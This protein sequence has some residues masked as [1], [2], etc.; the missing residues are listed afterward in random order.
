MD[1][2]SFMARSPFAAMIF[3]LLGVL[4]R[5]LESTINV[6]AFVKAG[7]FVAGVLVLVFVPQMTLAYNPVRLL[8]RGL[9][10]VML[11]AVGEGAVQPTM[12]GK[13]TV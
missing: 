10:P 1:I 13:V 6:I 11:V 2:T 5:P 7:K 9:A 4:K 12:A 3:S 8:I